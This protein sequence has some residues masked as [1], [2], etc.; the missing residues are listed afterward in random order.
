MMLKNHQKGLPSWLGWLYCV[1]KKVPILVKF[2]FTWF[3]LALMRRVSAWLAFLIVVWAKNVCVVSAELNQIMWRGHFISAGTYKRPWKGLVL[4]WSVASCLAST[5]LKLLYALVKTSHFSLNYNTCRL[6]KKIST[7]ERKH[8][9]GERWTLT[10]TTC[11]NICSAIE[12]KRRQHSL[13]A[14]Y[15]LVLERKFL[16]SL[17]R[18]YAGK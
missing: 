14:I 13:Q 12:D 16:C 17:V 11:L 8:G 15:K 6:N 10:S 7:M 3:Y 5:E 18:K 2:L 9:V 4:T 1:M